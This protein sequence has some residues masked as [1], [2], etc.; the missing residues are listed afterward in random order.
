[1]AE[2]NSWPGGVPVQKAAGVCAAMIATIATACGGADASPSAENPPLWNVPAWVNQEFGSLND[3][4][5]KPFVIY[6]GVF[7]G[8]PVGGNEQ[9]AAWSQELVFGATLDFEK[10]LHLP[11]AALVISGADAA[12]SNLSDDIGNIF[13]ASQAYVTPTMMFYELYWQQSLL[14]NALEFRVGRI[15]S[16][17]TFAALPAFG[18]QVNGGINGN[19]LSVFL[20]SE[21]TASPVATWGAYAK[22]APTSDTYAS[23]GIYQAT[24]RLGVTAY[25]GLDFSIRSNDGVLLLGEVGWTPTFAQAPTP[26]GKDGKSSSPP[27]SSATSGLPGTYIAGIYYSNLPE[28]EFLG[29]GTQQN[30]YGFYA[31]A[32]QMLWRSAANPNISFSLWGG[33]TGNPQPK[34]ATMPVMGFAGAIW[35]GLIPGRDQDQTLFSFL[36]GGW[37]ADYADASAAQGHGRPTTES[38]LE[39]SYIIQ[40]TQNLT[41]QPDIQYV[42]R[43]GGTGNIGD[44]LI[45]GVQVGASF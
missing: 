13:T 5:I 7:Q 36:I 14:D 15:S 20:N 30:S 22:Y 40:L 21:F 24:E 2:G 45:L 32:Q 6:Y 12:G 39:W 38:V 37:S 25:H 28:H 42:L 41:V 1:M 17:D 19:P 43:P 35:Q 26:T 11:G 3:A 18:L 34:I 23:A 9:S 44:A 16:G 27:A 31:L 8:N 10:L 4:G 33:A 29:N